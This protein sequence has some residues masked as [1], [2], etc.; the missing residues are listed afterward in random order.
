[1]KL[2]A[3][4]AI[5]VIST[6][7]ACSDSPS[8]YPIQGIASPAQEVGYPEQGIASPQQEISY[9]QQGIA[10]VEPQPAKP[11]EEKVNETS[12]EQTETKKPLFSEPMQ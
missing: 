11:I 8:P 5:V 1:M 10:T 7:T 6:L 2:Q 4:L 9:P 3:L 12:P